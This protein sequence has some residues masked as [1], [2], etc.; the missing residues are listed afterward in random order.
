MKICTKLTILFIIS[1]RN[2]ICHQDMKLHK[3]YTQHILSDH[4]LSLSLV[5][6]KKFS[7]LIPIRKTM[8]GLVIL[9][10]FQLSPAIDAEM[11]FFLINIFNIGARP[12][13]TSW[14]VTMNQPKRVAKFMDNFFFKTIH[15]KLVIACHS[16]TF[17]AKPVKRSNSCASI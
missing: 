14:G 13:Y 4:L 10:H 3:V 15:E 17:V 11:L 7:G 2:E 1:E 12:H 5:L 8:S 16:V 9:M 6:K